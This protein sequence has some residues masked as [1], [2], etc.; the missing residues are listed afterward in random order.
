MT[1]ATGVITVLMCALAGGAVWCVLALYTRFDFDAFLLAIAALLAWVLRSHG[2]ARSGSGIVLAVAATVLAFAYAAYL[3]A[4][5]KVASHLGLPMRST[6]L[7][8]GPEMAAAIA[9]A[10]FTAWQAGVLLLSCLLAGWIVWRP[11]RR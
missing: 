6:L 3:L 9:R 10:D 1:R 7:A 8:I 4:A 5:A 11:A 2:F